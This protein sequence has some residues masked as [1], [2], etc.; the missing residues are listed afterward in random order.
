MI[1]VNNADKEQ[2]YNALNELVISYTESMSNFMLVE[3]GQQA[4]KCYDTYCLN[5]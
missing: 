4:R 3:N 2:I 5:E 1:Q